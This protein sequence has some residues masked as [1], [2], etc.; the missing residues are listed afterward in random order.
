MKLIIPS[1][2]YHITNHLI[3][4]EQ[5]I[6]KYKVRARKVAKENNIIESIE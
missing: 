5:K 6:Y 3:Q 2:Y 4:K 1:W